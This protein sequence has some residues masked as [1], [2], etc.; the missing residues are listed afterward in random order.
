MGAI[1]VQLKVGII[2]VE[3][4]KTG[5]IPAINIDPA[6]AP[7]KPP[8]NGSQTSTDSNDRISQLRT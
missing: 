8:L 7:T 1:V 5:V 2:H 4:E 6:P 3:T